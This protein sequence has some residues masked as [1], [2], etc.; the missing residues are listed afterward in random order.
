[1]KE[2]TV[3]VVD[4]DA[5]RARALRDRLQALAYGTTT[6]ANGREAIQ[7]MMMGLPDVILLDITRPASD[8]AGLCQWLQL[9]PETAAIP[10]I[11]RPLGGS[12][13]D[14]TIALLGG[15]RHLF[16][17]AGPAATSGGRAAAEPARAPVT[18]EALL[19]QIAGVLNRRGLQMH[20]IQEVARAKRYRTP[21]SCV[22]LTVDRWD[23]LVI[24]H[25]QAQRDAVLR[26]LGHT[27][28][29]CCRPTDFV[30]R[31]G[32]EEFTVLLPHT[33]LQGALACAERIRRTAAAQVPTSLS[34]VSVGVAE[35]DDADE[36][37]HALLE[38][39]DAALYKAK[40]AGGNCVRADK[41]W[42]LALEP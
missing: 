13:D 29:A 1:M 19:D 42:E 33:G 30:A 25:S 15:A 37:E 24:A 4:D 9:Q 16:G 22:M 31:Y 35:H 41:S 34:T 38:R 8:A 40:A 23:E 21:L 2:P 28:V 32:G 20:L 3:L 12:H 7:Q 18:H 39:A 36:D 11:H 26:E 10:V 6:A 27:L 5:D 17:A 14:K